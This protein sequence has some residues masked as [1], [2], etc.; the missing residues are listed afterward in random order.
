MT[1]FRIIIV[2]ILFSAISI[3]AQKQIEVGIDEKLGA[4]LPLDTKFVTSENDTITL[5][6]V[7]NEPVLMA[8]VY[9]ECPGLCSPMLS[10]LAWTIDKIDLVPGKD[11]KVIALSFDHHE[12]VKLSAKWKPNY[13]H[14]I[15]RDIP[16]SSWL[17]L[18]GDSIN[19][20]K[21]TDAVGFFFKPTQEDFIHAG[22]VITVSPKGMISRY[23]F[24]TSYNPFDTKMALIDA[25]SGKTNPT[26][27]KVLEFCFSY[28]PAGRQYTLN[29]TRIIGTV[30]LLGVGIFA[31]VLF[32]KKRKKNI[33]EKEQQIDD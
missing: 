1:Y 4:Y 26:I 30:M 9:F 28:D 31:G 19:I 20:K 14:L 8:L 29:I 15:K 33:E 18:T 25:G 12:D 5:G 10:E 32:F 11:F 7:I 16:D 24:G 3:S 2:I 21:V 13:M 23:L 22:T 27:A 6:E 17:F